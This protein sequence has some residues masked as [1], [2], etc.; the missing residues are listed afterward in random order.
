VSWGQLLGFDRTQS[1]GLVA[2]RL[3]TATRPYSDRRPSEHEHEDRATY[4]TELNEDLPDGVRGAHVLELH[5]EQ[6]GQPPRTPKV[7]AA[8]RV[9]PSE[10]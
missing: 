6:Y 9:L 2:V 3:P 5:D 4:I 8:L 1:V 7:S 10:P